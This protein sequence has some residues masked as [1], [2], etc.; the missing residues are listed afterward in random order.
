MTVKITGD[1]A[2]LKAALEEAKQETQAAA[3]SME[4]ASP[5]KIGMDE[6]VPATEAVKENTKETAA[7]A[8]DVAEETE[9]S[10]N[11]ADRLR[12]GI[13]DIKQG[14]AAIAAVL[15][16]AYA[17]G[18]LIGTGLE[19]AFSGGSMRDFDEAAR[20]AA[21]RL[22]KINAEVEK[23]KERMKERTWK[24]NLDDL[25]S[26]GTAE[27]KLYSDRA[28]R[29][30]EINELEK[31]RAR[32]ISSTQRTQHE[33]ELDAL[34]VQADL[35]MAG[36]DEVEKAKIR[37]AQAVAEAQNKYDGE[38]KE[39]ALALV[40]TIYDAQI[41]AAEKAAREK[42]M[43]DVRARD[44]AR[45]EEEKQANEKAAREQERREEKTRKEIE[46][47]QRVARMAQEI[48]DKTAAAIAS[49]FSKARTDFASALSMKDLVIGV[50]ALN[51]NLDNMRRN[52][53]QIAAGDIYSG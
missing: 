51:A 3:Q 22:V 39:R 53:Q 49:A 27:G 8:K 28:K 23:L 17:T 44:I 16:G 4:A 30:Q 34:K 7:A 1:T 47:A 24:T 46:E 11:S 45:L 20:D 13:G 10:A 43:M 5:G 35:A 41:A 19:E 15:A 9:K 37:K 21:D 36:D 18:N 25:L 2:P 42:Y 48:A 50:Q 26:N 40:N 31:E 6:L 33:R 52:R 29:Q 14:V 12:A 38:Q 32:I